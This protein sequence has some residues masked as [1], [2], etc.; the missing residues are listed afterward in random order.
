MQVERLAPR[1][2]GLV[3]PVL[4]EDADRLLEAIASL[5]PG[6]PTTLNLAE[7]TSIDEGG[8]AAIRRAATKAHDIGGVLILLLPPSE[9][10]DQIRGSGLDE[11]P[12]ILVEVLET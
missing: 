7:V 1:T 9:T 8:M 4:A 3:G 12:L 10:L 6:G 2:L 11:E 5:G